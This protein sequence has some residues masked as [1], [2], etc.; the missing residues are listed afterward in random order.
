[1]KPR[2]LL[3]LLALLLVAGACVLEGA[4][5]LENAGLASES[6]PG[7]RAL[8]ARLAALDE[9]VR[10]T[11]F[12]SAPAYFEGE[13][14][15]LD[16][17]VRELCATLARA[18]EGRV[19]C[20]RVDPAS[21]PALG[22]HAAALGLAPFRART[23][24]RDGW[25][26][27]TLWST[28][29]VVV[30]ARGTLLVEGLSPEK[31]AYLPRL[32]E[33]QLDGLLAPRKPRILLES[34]EDLHGL[35]TELARLSDPVRG[36]F[37][38]DSK[39]VETPDLL[40]WI[41]PR[42][43][44]PA[45][46]AALRSL[47]ERGTSVVLAGS[48]WTSALERSGFPAATLLGEFGLAPE[49][50]PLTQEGGPVRSTGA[51]QDFRRFAGQPNGTLLFR[52]PTSFVPDPARLEALALDF[53][54]L[55]ASSEKTAL[56]ENAAPHATLAALLEPRD[57]WRGRL[58]VF[59]AATPFEDPDLAAENYAH[60]ALLEVLVRTL[61]SPERRAFASVA[62]TQP[63]P[64]PLVGRGWARTL[65]VGAL[66]LALALFWFARRR[67]AAP[68]SRRWP[69]R[70]IGAAAA[71]LALL[72]FV[73][74]FAPAGWALDATREGAN[75]LAPELVDLCREAG[76]LRATL[77]FSPDERL[78]SEYRPEL[79]NLR[80]LLERLRAR[81]GTLEIAE[82]RI[83]AADAPAHGLH[84][85]RVTSR[86]D[87]T[88]LV[89]EIAAG[90]LLERDG[91]SERLEFPE[92]ASFDDLAFRLG[93][94]FERLRTGKSVRIAAATDR[95]RLSPA[96]S[97]LA[98]ESKQ[99]FA[100][101][102]GDPYGRARALL[103]EHD[104][105]LESVS[106]ESPAPAQPADLFLWL[107]PRRDIQP[108]RSE[109]ERQL[110]AGGKAL[111]AAQ[112][113]VVRPRARAEHASQPAWWPE[114]QLCDLEQ[115][116]PASAGVELVLE[117]FFDDLCASA[118]LDESVDRESAGRRI[119][120]TSGANPLLVRAASPLG[121]LLMPFA[122]RIQL[123]PQALGART[124]VAS[125]PRCWSLEWK[126]GDL[127]P[128]EFSS[129]GKTMLGTQPLAV[130]S[131]SF[132]LIGCSTMFQDAWIEREGCEN[133]RFLVQCAARLTLPER[134]V[135]LLA[136]RAGAPVLPWVEPQRRSWLRASMLAA[137]PLVL[138]VLAAAWTLVRR[139]KAGA[140]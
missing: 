53:H 65:V 64:L 93:F 121:E 127:P 38:R 105:K 80:E 67:R 133:A 125:S 10:V 134:V 37:D 100:P 16:P 59:G 58:V 132:T 112:H 128:D 139:R 126:G 40:F 129:R 110:A 66:P 62:A 114:R 116:W 22:A 108:L 47:L 32:L 7:E 27:T 71:G 35:E 48:A 12:A 19:R 101:T 104:F 54:I 115:G 21:D 60:R 74:A 88:T 56:G 36:S 118:Q 44:S 119:E 34:P 120:R 113:Y 94:A 25:R 55:A 131:D 91:R 136:R 33:A 130:E 28:L 5:A 89:R 50:Q 63:A 96:E 29:R 41:A 30:G 8:A 9:D 98:Y 46:L 3:P 137:A 4:R 109:L 39:L 24:E 69:W 111:V 52:A 106:S 26:E 73:R 81:S 43:V 123:A 13:Y 138:L 83:E 14:R 31:L 1:M 87:E 84:A 117:V 45:Q 68:Q 90:L 107:Q 42:A 23:V 95:P 103:A 82:E 122:N 140:A 86:Q 20:S 49:R 79:A 102:S 97:R 85:L 6:L 75:A 11:W 124:L 99:L 57:P 51:E 18:S 92:R 77:C 76:P 70:T 2:E 135:G 61:A 15:R 72:A 78:P 17:A